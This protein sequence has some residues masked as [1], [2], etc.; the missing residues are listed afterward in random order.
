MGLLGKNGSPTKDW[1]SCTLPPALD[2]D[3][4]D[5]YRHALAIADPIESRPTRQR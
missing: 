1:P 2:D 5:Q 4:I 3:A